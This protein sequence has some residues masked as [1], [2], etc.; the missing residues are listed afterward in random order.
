MHLMAWPSAAP[1]IATTVPF[2][3]QRFHWFK[4]DIIK[5]AFSNVF[6]KSRLLIVDEHSKQYSVQISLC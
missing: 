4:V 1:L 3:A 5:S 2:H 6:N